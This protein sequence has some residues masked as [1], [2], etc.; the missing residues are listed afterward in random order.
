MP[1][2]LPSPDDVEKNWETLEGTL[3]NLSEAQ[4]GY[5]LDGLS[6]D[7]TPNGGNTEQSVSKEIEDA[8]RLS[9]MDVSDAGKVIPRRT[10]SKENFRLAKEALDRWCSRREVLLALKSLEDAESRGFFVVYDVGLGH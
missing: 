8:W 10:S 9:S 5:L 3:R 7:F 2:I 4:V 6:N 1:A